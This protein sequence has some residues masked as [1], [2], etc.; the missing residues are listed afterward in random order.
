MHTDDLR[1]QDAGQRQPGATGTAREAAER[2]AARQ[3][4]ARVAAER[5]DRPQRHPY[6]GIADRALAQRAFAILADNVRDYAI[7]LLD[8]DGIIRFWG[9]GA[10]RIKSWSRDEAEGAHLRLL[11][12][13]GGAEDGTAEAHLAQAESGEYTGEGRRVRG[14]GST[15]WAG[16]TL[17]ALR[18]RDGELL[19][20]V[21]STRDLT[22]RRAAEAMR[23]A[24]DRSAEEGTQVKSQFLATVSHEVRTPLTS[25]MAYVDLMKMELAGPLTDTQHGYLDTMRASSEHLLRIIE[26]ILDMSRTEAGHTVVDRDRV[27]VGTVVARAM[28]LM[29]VQAARRGVE[30]VDAVSALATDLWCWGD[31]GRVR[32]ILL[33]LLSNAVK[34]TEPGGRVTI[35]AGSAAE[36]PPDAELPA[37]AR[38]W[39]FI[40]VEDTGPG[41]PDDRLEAI[42]EPF[43]QIDMSATRSHGG[44]GLSLA[45]SRS[46]ALLMDG[47]ITVRSDVGVGSTFFIWLPAALDASDIAAA[48]AT[49]VLHGAGSMLAVKDAI[50]GELERILKSY[51]VRLRADTDVPSARNT[52][53]VVIEDH[54]AS[55]LADIAQT[56]GSVDLAAGAGAD[57]LRDGTIIQRTIAERHG[58]QRARLRWT[59][60]EVRREFAILQEEVLAAVQRRVRLPRQEEMDEISRV[61]T[62]ILDR[63]RRLAMDSYASRTHRDL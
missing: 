7:F 6:H 12:P 56:M 19:G 52:A 33:N 50:L 43:V 58:A 20:F 15:F 46:L 26:D 55:F 59:E 61:I 18:D 30:V 57:M 29:E 63:A 42:F 48:V 21:K 1:D 44:T 40:R 54:L 41:I 17:T 13:D 53:Q 35:S 39:V 24:A 2:R 10:R 31:E 36:P 60:P 49:P 47:D 22:A 3:R 51:V 8:R 45:I 28:R 16:V 37:S 25:I 34:F 32:Q 11:Y 14:D 23:D 4:A 27:R 5:T 62:E 38:S 9:E